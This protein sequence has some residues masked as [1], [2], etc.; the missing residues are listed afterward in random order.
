MLRGKRNI[1]IAPNIQKIMDEFM[2]ETKGELWDSESELKKYYLEKKNYEKLLNGEVVPSVYPADQPIPETADL[3]VGVHISKKDYLQNKNKIF[4]KIK[5]K[6]KNK[7]IIIRSSSLQEDK[8]I[9]QMLGNIK[10]SK[11]LSLKK[12]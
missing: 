3:Q 12:I 7:R 10:H 1:P 6:F 9:Y 4:N 8:S 11:I 2:A 5:K